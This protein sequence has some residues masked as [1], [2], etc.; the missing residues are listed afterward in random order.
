MALHINIPFSFECDIYNVL[1]IILFYKL[2][3]TYD[4]LEM[5]QLCKLGYFG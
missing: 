2:I 3:S 4:I 5:W 1:N